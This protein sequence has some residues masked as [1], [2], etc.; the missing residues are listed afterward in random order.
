MSGI[1][2][3]LA[4][5]AVAIA[6]SISPTVANAAAPPHSQSAGPSHALVSSAQTKKALSTLRIKI[7][8]LPSTVKASV[9]ISGPKKYN[10]KITQSVKLKLPAGKYKLRMRPVDTPRDVYKPR[11]ARATVTVKKARVARFTVRY[12]RSSSPGPTTPTTPPTQPR[13]PRPTFDATV[14]WLPAE[15]A[16]VACQP[17]PS[18]DTNEL[19][20]DLCDKEGIS[21]LEPSQAQVRR[22]AAAE[23]AATSN[24]KTIEDNGTL[25]EAVV[26][27]SIT[28]QKV[29]VGPTGKTY[30]SLTR[31][32]D[33]NDTTSSDNTCAF[34]EV[35]EATG[36]PTCVDSTIR[37]V[38]RITFDNAGNVYYSGTATNSVNT[39]LRKW[40]GASVRNLL[41]NESWLIDFAVT[42]DGYVVVSGRTG[43]TGSGWTRM[44]AA[45]GSLSNIFSSATANWISLYPDGNIYMGMW[46][47]EETGIRRLLTATKTLDPIYWTGG[48]INNRPAPPTYF[49]VEDFCTPR[50]DAFCGSWGTSI[51]KSVITQEGKVLVQ[52]GA[53]GSQTLM[54]YWPDVRYL[55]TAV[56]KV[57]KMES[58]GEMLFLAGPNQN[59]DNIAAFFTP[60]NGT[61]QVV[62]SPS[63][64]I[65]IY[66]ASYSADTR[67]VIF[68]GLRFADNQRVIGE[69]SVDTGAVTVHATNAGRLSNLQAF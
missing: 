28:A 30:L 1:N 38:Y 4:A 45:N 6:L 69:I 40:D 42:A 51:T 37:S 44:V 54:Q 46:G 49:P 41:S 63:N 43:T 22:T 53:P 36:I 8:G 2:N 50:V 13:P 20:L 25:S 16:R 9:R 34:F 47:M 59:G 10:K 26:S 14:R 66:N 27:G 17:A 29:Q 48:A 12:V 23:P 55:S 56:T 68:D 21:L 58:A 62:I 39:V 15:R 35:N 67:K 31:P 3:R 57:T 65:E 61:E 33:P 19:R 52:V 64:Q 60:A 24:L 11:A 5:T 18:P 32:V 7:S